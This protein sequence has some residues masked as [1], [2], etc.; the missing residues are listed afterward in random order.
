M[1]PVKV[2][3][4]SEIGRLRG[5]I[6][7]TPGEEVENMTPR[8]AQRAL[9]SDIL[10]LSIAQKEYAQL[11]GVLE[12]WTD[13]YQVDKLLGVVL[14][15][16]GDRS[17]LLKR[18][19]TIENVPEYYD[20]LMGT[21]T[22][23]L[24]RLLLEGLPAKIDTLTAFLADD[25]YALQP[26]YNF[27]FT[28]DA[29]A[30]I[31]EDVLICKMAN[32][33]RVR[34]SLIM[35]AIFSNPKLFD[36]SIIDANEFSKER[37]G[38]GG[39]AG[40]SV[41]NNVSVEGGDIL[42]IDK[43]ILLVGNGLRTTSQGIDRLI[44]RFCQ[45]QDGDQKHIIV[46]QLPDDVESFIHMDMVFTMLDN[47]ACLI[48]EPLILWEN[49]YRTVHITIDG[50]RVKKI[51]T[52]Q[53]VLSTLRKLGKDLEPVLCGGD[54]DEWNADREQWHS[55]ANSF[56]IAPGKIL[57]YA[58]NVH[59]LNALNQAGFNIVTADDV[60]NDKVD[61]EKEK[62]CVIT[63]EGSELPRGGGGARCMTMPVVRDD[64]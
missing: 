37:A 1:D 59:T 32:K 30:S 42:V 64:I 48:Y 56:A 8:I 27:Y 49:Q 18:I 55:G 26:L 50:G 13:T 33:V 44:Q 7:H 2:K 34:E 52:E 54:E 24:T 51:R 12:K 20:M 39:I 9:Y 31:G 3:V 23:K 46:Q 45:D 53:N 25:Y 11:R 62:R 57:S 5:V 19:C 47:D 58:R 14:D 21:S 6:L 15:D 40:S 41:K 60:I 38:E 35:E 63:I 10:N 4:H 43:N 36:C 16:P 61:L 17:M 22:K 29:S 28:R